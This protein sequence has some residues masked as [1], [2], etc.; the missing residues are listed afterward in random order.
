MNSNVGSTDRAL[1]TALGAITGIVSLVILIGTMTLPG[2]TTLPQILTG[3]STLPQILSP[4]LGVIAAILLATAV[5]GT[6]P[7]YSALGLNSQ[8][9]GPGTSQ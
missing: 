7:M 9:R 5:M 1:R 2:T 8:S 3:V 4:V 6:C